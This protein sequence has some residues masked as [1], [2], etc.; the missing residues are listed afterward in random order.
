MKE[1]QHSAAGGGPARGQPIVERK[2]K[3]DGTV[4]EYPCTLLHLSGGLAVIRFVMGRG[5]AVWGTPIEVP[6]ASVSDGYFWKRRPYNLYRMRRA[7]GSLIAHRFDAVADVQLAPDAITYRDLVLDWWVMPDETIIEE[8]R[9]EFETAVASKE[10]G[11]GDVAAA[12]RAAQQVL[13]R[14]RHIIDE[15][16]AL[17]RRLDLRL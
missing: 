12:R 14:Y 9:E 6:V 1:R 16:E 10:M 3:P 7:D 17:E 15:V 5:G 11:A 8:D 13:G 2:I 4:R